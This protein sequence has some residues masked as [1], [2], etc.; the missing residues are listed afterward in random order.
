MQQELHI[1]IGN[2]FD[3]SLP[4]ASKLID[5]GDKCA[6]IPVYNSF[7]MPLNVQGYGITSYNIQFAQ[8]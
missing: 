2:Q 4:I 6:G 1:Y 7:R 5:A 3:F 8:D